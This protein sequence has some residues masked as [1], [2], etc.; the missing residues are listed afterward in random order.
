MTVFR[1]LYF[2]TFNIDH[3]SGMQEPVPHG[4]SHDFHTSYVLIITG[5]VAARAPSSRTIPHTTAGV[6]QQHYGGATACYPNPV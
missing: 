4:V 6:D 2:I 1:I 5:F 3:E